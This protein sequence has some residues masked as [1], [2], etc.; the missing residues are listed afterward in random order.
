M[1]KH[2][3]SLSRVLAFIL[4]SLLLT[5][6]A[7]GGTPAATTAPASVQTT[8]AET[9]PEPEVYQW[10]KGVKKNNYNGYGFVILNGCT[11]T[12]FSRNSVMAEELTGETVN[13]AIFERTQR[14]E[15]FLNVKVSEISN[16]D[17]TAKIKADVKAGMTDYDV[18]LC[19]LM[20][21]FSVAL[22]GNT[23][24]LNTIND[25]VD[26]S[27]VWW[28]TNSV[29]DLTIN[30]KLYLISSDF[31][32]TRLDS[33][34][35]MFFNKK[36][37]EDLKLENPYDLV[38]SG[39]WTLD[40]FA[41]M[42]KAGE[43]DLD[44]DGVMTDNDRYGWVTYTG[45][46]MDLLSCASNYSYIEK[47][48]DGKLVSGVS[49]ESFYD[50]YMKLYD[51]MWNTNTVFDSQ[52]SRTSAYR[53]G[54]SDRILEAL[55]AED[56]GVFYSE[57]LAWF[58]SMREMESDFGIVPPPKANEDQ[59]R[60]YSVMINPFMQQIPVTNTETGRTLNVLDVLAAA[61]HDTVVDA[62]VN[63]TLGG[64]VARDADTVRMMHLVFDELRYNLHFS[65]VAI[66]STIYNLFKAGDD[67]IASTL[68][69]NETAFNTS[70]AEV[71]AFFFG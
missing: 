6:C 40:K 30:K 49:D 47:D 9:E 20:T 19:T 35:S 44:G 51:I 27:N 8:A 33:I 41:A 65:T 32:T 24:D 36:L 54:L 31:D 48:R 46:M 55:F 14:T 62:Y 45:I 39:K 64:K 61:S 42:C 18:A 60:Y 16:S 12:W 53:R 70:L 10:D 68:K 29:N 21:S 28:D 56:K 34:R 4:L 63:V 23:Y 52:G 1:K 69:S 43:S 25:N 26:F 13:D 22:E 50:C 59:D 15:E 57:C 7:G 11:A 58:R 5:A 71:N 3:S 66:R 67:S 2:F 37:I 38:D 17:S